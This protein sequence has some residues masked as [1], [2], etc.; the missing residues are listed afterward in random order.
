MTK[1]KELTIESSKRSM[2]YKLAQSEMKV[3]LAPPETT[4]LSPGKRKSSIVL[5]K[6]P[7]HTSH[8]S[9]SFYV[10]E[11][12]PTPIDSMYNDDS[13]L[14]QIPNLSML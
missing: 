10:S 2:N 1:N 8:P 3:P 6:N 12:H 4:I 13:R 7:Q 5:E 9:D 14:S 11:S